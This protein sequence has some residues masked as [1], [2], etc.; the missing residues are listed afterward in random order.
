MQVNGTADDAVRIELL[1]AYFNGSAA[2]ATPV[3]SALR[4]HG[5]P[6]HPLSISNLHAAV[7][8][9]VK[10]ISPPAAP[11]QNFDGFEFATIQ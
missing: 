10:P 5:P 2:S 7:A 8:H 3:Q 11:A 6:L 4:R 9:I 1:K